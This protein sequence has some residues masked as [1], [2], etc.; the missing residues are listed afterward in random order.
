MRIDLHINELLYVKS[1]ASA[2]NID[3]GQPGA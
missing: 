3:P 2:K 1:F